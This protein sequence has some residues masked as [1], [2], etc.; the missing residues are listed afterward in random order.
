MRENYY[1]TTDN[2]TSL[3]EDEQLRDSLIK[4]I[5]ILDKVKE[6][7]LLPE[8]ECLT[9]KQ[10]A[11][12]YE[13]DTEVL[14]KCYQRNKIE[15]DADGVKTETPKTIK[16]ILKWTRCPIKKLE[17]LNGKLIMQVDD[18]TT[19]VIPNRGIKM[20]PKRAI[21]HIGM[22]LRDSE[23]AKEVRTQLLNIFE[24][25]EVH[26]PESLTQAIDEEETLALNVA[27][28][29]MTGD[30]LTFAE[31][32]MALNQFHKRHIEKLQTAN[33]QL[34]EDNEI[35]AN[36]IIKLSMRNQIN[37]MI[38]MLYFKLN[39][40]YAMVWSIVYKQLKYKYGINL[41]NR[42]DRKK[43][44]IQ[45]LKE[46]EFVNLQDVISALLIKNN[47]SPSEFFDKCKII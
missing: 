17:Q 25:A 1:R 21:L 16:K 20:F 28:A 3:L 9:I 26:N 13:V 19:I 45:Y 47:I 33:K 46:N 40:D 41:K 34:S 43:P 18:S 42:G 8:L 38:R 10:V 14:N 27:K 39:I 24:N 29:Y 12:Y 35:L 23:V 4:R 31:A 15:I 6:L 37:R 32:A 11:E 36:E 2:E 22:L 7:F 5:D 44:Y 30:M